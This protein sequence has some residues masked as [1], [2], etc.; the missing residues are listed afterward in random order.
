MKPEAD[1]IARLQRTI[2]AMT[3]VPLHDVARLASYAKD[4][5]GKAHLWEVVEAASEVEL[6]ANKNEVTLQ[7]SIRHLSEALTRAESWDNPPSITRNLHRRFRG[8]LGRVRGSN[9]QGRIDQVAINLSVLGSAAKSG[10]DRATRRRPPTERS[11][12]SRAHLRFVVT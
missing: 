7:P 11:L 2:E 9:R 3:T 10:S 1:T 4:E 6:E 8:L 12:F 5:A